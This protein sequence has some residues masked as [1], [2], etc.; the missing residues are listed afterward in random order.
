MSLQT[1]P[2]IQ[3]KTNK[4]TNKGEKRILSKYNLE[5]KC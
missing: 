5:P 3:I 4:E 1:V 2:E